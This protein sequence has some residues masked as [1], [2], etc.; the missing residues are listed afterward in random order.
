MCILYSDW[1]SISRRGKTII[2]GRTV[3]T[4][5]IFFLNRKHY[6]N[7]Y[8]YIPHIVN[9]IDSIASVSYVSRKYSRKEILTK[10]LAMFYVPD[11]DAPPPPL[12]LEKC[13]AAAE[14]FT[15]VR[16]P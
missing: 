16:P 11:A 2:Y 1:N 8:F 15:I 13:R 3:E 12:F 10:I 5:S 7:V 6:K 14:K 4:I 9:S